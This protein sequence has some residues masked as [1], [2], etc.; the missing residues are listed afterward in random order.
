MNGGRTDG[1]VADGRTDGWLSKNVF[2]PF[3]SHPF[4]SKR[5]KR[6]YILFIQKDKTRI[7]LKKG[8]KSFLKAIRPSVRHSSV[9]P[10][11]SAFY[12]NPLKRPIW[13]VYWRSNFQNKH[14]LKAEKIKA[15]KVYV[16][17]HDFLSHI[18]QPTR[19]WF[20]LSFP[21]ELLMSVWST[22]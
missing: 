9:R 21:H 8:W 12:P 7:W 22:I 3:L 11:V 17:E 19:Y 16:N 15:I 13:C 10:S 4:L 14:C 18:K 20:P 5:I 1:W 2:Q 6:G